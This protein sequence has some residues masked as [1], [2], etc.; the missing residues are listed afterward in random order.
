MTLTYRAPLP[1]DLFLLDPDVVFLNHGSFGATPRPVF[2]KYLEWQRELERQ[3]V[4][5]L[6]V[7]L[8]GLLREARAQLAT[9]VHTARDNLVFVSNATTGCNIVAR[10]LALQP[11]DEILTTDHE[12]GAM[13]RMWRF[14][15]NKTG[16]V[17]KRQPIPLPVTTPA[18][19]VEAVW[20]GV[21]PRT[22][23]L[24]LSHITSPTALT[25]PVRELCRRTRAAGILS[26]VDGAHALGQL[27]LD[28]DALGADFYTSNAHKWLCAPKG[29]AF[30]YARP[31]VQSLVEPLVVS[32]G[33]QADPPGAS[34]FIDEQEWTGTRDPSAWLAVP[35]A[36]RFVEGHAWDS[37]RAGCH[38]LARYARERITA[39][40]GLPPISPDSMDWY[41]QMVTLPLPPCDPVQFKRRLLDEFHIEIPLIVWQERPFIRV[42]VQAYNTLEDIDRLVDA[43][44]VLTAGRPTTVADEN[45]KGSQTNE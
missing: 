14:M 35:E 45:H 19:F 11:G 8:S 7:R 20:S 18:D 43:L 23:V 5:F 17:Y 32:W 3:P 37:V 30:L 25:F 9:Y 26:L 38:A 33:Y 12:Y 10:S 34:R 28:L 16:A 1:K 40:T 44:Q 13:D 27:P 15:S 29:A 41:V 4:E 21:T 22:R 39:L 36:I 6:G 2:E 42:S 31:E 24:F